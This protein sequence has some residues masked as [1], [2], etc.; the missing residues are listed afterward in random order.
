MSTR[1]WRLSNIF[2]KYLSRLT[3]HRPTK[4]PATDR[5]NLNQGAIFRLHSR[6]LLGEP[7]AILLHRRPQVCTSMWMGF[8]FVFPAV[9]VVVP[10]GNEAFTTK[11]PAWHSRSR[12]N[13]RAQITQ[14]PPPS[15]F[16]AYLLG[17]NAFFS[18]FCFGSSSVFV[19]SAYIKHLITL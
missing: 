15:T 12:K 10:N 14:G 11:N 5:P 2:R 6:K 13:N 4:E 16:P 17:R 19:G 3:R 8:G 1:R 7:R 9:V 18:R